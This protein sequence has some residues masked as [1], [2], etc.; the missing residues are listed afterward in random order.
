MRDQQ[1]GN[2]FDCTTII[3]RA[4]L[5]SGW[6]DP[7]KATAKGLKADAFFRR[8]ID[9]DGLSVLKAG[10]MEPREFGA[11][12]N[13]CHGIATLHVGR[14][15]DLGVTVAPDPEDERKLLLTNIPFENPGDAAQEKLAGDIAKSARIINIFTPPL[16]EGSRPY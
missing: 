4:I 9:T 5:K 13:P 6:I 15:L 8:K 12:F 2:S 7:D 14:L 11:T 16:K 10:T 3:Y 1:Q